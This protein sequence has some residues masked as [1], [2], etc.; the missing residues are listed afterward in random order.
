V[1]VLCL[2]VVAVP[3]GR[4]V[5]SVGSASR[6][7]ATVPSMRSPAVVGARDHPVQVP[8]RV[9]VPGP[10]AMTPGGADAHPQPVRPRRTRLTVRVGVAVGVGGP[11]WMAR[12]RARKRAADAEDDSAQRH[13]TGD[14]TEAPAADREL[15]A[16]AHWPKARRGFAVRFWLL[17]T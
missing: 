9:P 5:T 15:G 3:L 8:V 6:V 2:L 11:G 12:V 10:R 4:A 17:G 16:P 14:G 13:Q 1:G 7:T